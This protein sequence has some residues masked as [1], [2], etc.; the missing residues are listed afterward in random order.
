MSSM[1]GKPQRKALGE[2]KSN[3]LKQFPS[4]AEK[5]I[6]QASKE[7][8]PADQTEAEVTDVEMESPEKQEEE[9]VFPVG[10]TD[11][12]SLEDQNN[13]QLCVEYASAIYAY[14]RD[15]E[16]GLSIKKDFLQG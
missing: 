7:L 6:V 16:N 8:A 2:L 15:V 5:K 4:E 13:P 9:K 1:A 11:I 3:N 10:V 12:D 14:L